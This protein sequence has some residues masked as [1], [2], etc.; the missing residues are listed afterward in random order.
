[1]PTS[2]PV[3]PEARYAALVEALLSNPAVNVGIAGK[4]GF[5]AAALCIKEK[6]F[7]ML[8]RDR[9]VVKIPRQ[10]VDALIALLYYFVSSIIAM[11]TQFYIFNFL[12][13]APSSQ[14]SVLTAHIILQ[15]DPPKCFANSDVFLYIIDFS[16][17][18][19]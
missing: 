10:R 1:M 11:Y 15:S 13:S 8:S 3:T 18:R 17:N 12:F 4:K 5:G 7:A 9:L 6:I 2:T 16:V 19:R 14:P